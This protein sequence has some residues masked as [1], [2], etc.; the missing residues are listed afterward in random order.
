MSESCVRRKGEK[1]TRAGVPIHNNR[2]RFEMKNIQ[3]ISY[4]NIKRDM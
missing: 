1:G 2:K 4:N 3:N